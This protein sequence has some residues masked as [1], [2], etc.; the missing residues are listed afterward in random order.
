MQYDLSH[1]AHMTFGTD[2][3]R[4]VGNMWE[5][6]YNFRNI[7]QCWPIVYDAGPT[8]G[9]HLNKNQA[10]FE[11]LKETCLYPCRQACHIK[12]RA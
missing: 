5:T 1:S 10:A 6:D 2:R 11:N 3:I 4:H 9:T 12:K 8:P 7:F